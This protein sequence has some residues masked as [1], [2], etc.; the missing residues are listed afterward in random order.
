MLYD[1]LITKGN[2]F[3]VDRD[4][5]SARNIFIKQLTSQLEIITTNIAFVAV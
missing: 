4:I 5:N 2:G 1:K 3:T